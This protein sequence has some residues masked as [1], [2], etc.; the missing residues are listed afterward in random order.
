VESVAVSEV[1]IRGD[2]DDRFNPSA[3]RQPL[4]DSVVAVISSSVSRLLSDVG[5]DRIIVGF[6]P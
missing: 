5:P 2:S 1:A 4:D 6:L 3:V